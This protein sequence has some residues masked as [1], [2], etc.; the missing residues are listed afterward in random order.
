[1]NKYHKRFLDSFAAENVVA[2]F[3]RYK[4]AHKEITESW[5][6]LEAAKAHVPNI[7]EHTV[8]VIGDGCSPRTGALFAYFTKCKVISVDPNFNLS[9]W[10]EHKNKQESMGVPVQ[11]LTLIKDKIENIEFKDLNKDVLLLYPHSH[12]D[13]NKINL[14]KGSRVTIIAMPCCVAIPRNFME[15]P[16]KMW[17][18]YNVLSPKNEIHIWK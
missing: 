7:N 1:M 16:H 3:S 18:D 13:M 5:S 9:H 17:K 6:L 15:V 8:I 4:G 12:A 2:L 11:R 14:P 10:E